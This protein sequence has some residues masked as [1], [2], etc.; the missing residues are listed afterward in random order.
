MFSI[1]SLLV[2]DAVAGGGLCR[3][4]G[5]GG[6]G[7]VY[8]PSVK[9]A[10]R[11]A[12]KRYTVKKEYSSGKRMAATGSGPAA[13]PTNPAI[14]RVSSRQSTRHTSR[15][16]SAVFMFSFHRMETLTLYNAV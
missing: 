5:A 1:C 9:K 6:G 10:A 8:V 3:A 7:A 11:S 12:L 2:V 15:L 14:S 16:C 13:E 4:R